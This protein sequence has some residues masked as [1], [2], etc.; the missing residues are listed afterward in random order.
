MSSLDYLLS[1]SLSSMIIIKLGKKTFEK[2]E[3]RLNER[4]GIS[5]VEAIRDFQKMDATLREFFGAGADEI[6][7]DFLSNFLSVDNTMREKSWIKIENQNLANLILES[8]GNPDKKMILD[9]A[10]KQPNVILDILDSCNLPQSSGYRIIKNMIK[11]GLLITKGHAETR[12]GKKVKKYTSLFKNIK[13]EIQDNKTIVKVQL[14][15]DL[16]KESFLLKLTQTY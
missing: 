7:K 12:D 10:L 15:K 2:I 3:K 8:F 5:V 9:S 6:E 16:I 13:I 1:E 4:Y 14:D 11:E